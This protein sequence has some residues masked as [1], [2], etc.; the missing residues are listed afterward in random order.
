MVAY[1]LSLNRAAVEQVAERA[2]LRLV[3]DTTR[4][5]LNRAIILTPVRRG[6]LR[7]GNQM[8]VKK[9]AAGIVGEVFNDTAYAAAVHNGTRPHRITPKRA[10]VLRF[11]ATK[12]ASGKRKRKGNIVYTRY[13]NRP[14]T[15]G[16]PWLATALREVAGPAGFRV[17]V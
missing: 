3:T 14:G 12:P 5:V 13:V 7:A 8:R 4:R 9:D 16:R 15:K 17:T 2:A 10:K 6:R 11:K 1:Q